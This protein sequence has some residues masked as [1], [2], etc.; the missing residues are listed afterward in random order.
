MVLYIPRSRKSEIVFDFVNQS[1][2][3]NQTDFERYL[4]AQ[5]VQFDYEFGAEWDMV[6][7]VACSQV[8]AVPATA[9][10]LAVLDD[11]D[12]ANALG[13]HDDVKGPNGQ[14]FA[15]VFARTD[16]QVGANWTVTAS[17]EALET[18]G[19]PDV[20]VV[21]MV[22]GARFGGRLGSLVLAA[23][24]LCDACEADKFAKA[25][26]VGGKKGTDVMLSDFVTRAWFEDPQGRA[27]DAYGHLTAP[28]QIGDQGYIGLYVPGKGW[29]QAFHNDIGDL[30]KILVDRREV[31]TMALSRGIRHP[32][33]DDSPRR[34]ARFSKGALQ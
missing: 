29:T 16:V 1:T 11:S 34:K 31:T 4:K 10:Q 12:Q 25:F 33:L 21:V 23:R 17:H 2:V 15:K 24:E 3:V 7:K 26:R 6:L 8:E 9:W 30:S 27:V 5:Q 19:D 28:W 14:P 32:R 20:N 13:Y 22:D 18:P